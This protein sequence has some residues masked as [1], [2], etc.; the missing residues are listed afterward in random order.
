MNTMKLHT[1]VVL[2]DGSQ[3]WSNISVYG[4]YEVKLA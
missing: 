1:C 3:H 2:K 4:M